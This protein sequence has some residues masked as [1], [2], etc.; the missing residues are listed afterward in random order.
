MSS[1]S[2][3][4]CVP[5]LIPASQDGDFSEVRFRLL[6][7][8]NLAN[9]VGNLLNRT[10]NLLKKNAGGSVPVDAVAI[11]ADHPLRAVVDEQVGGETGP[12]F[13]IASL[14]SLHS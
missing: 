5:T 13:S 4:A 8:A 14:T 11:P 10:L 6:V 9:D 1:S 7:N 2:Y 12:S 3:S